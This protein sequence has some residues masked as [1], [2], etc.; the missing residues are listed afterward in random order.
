MVVSVSI[1]DRGPF[2]FLVDTGTNTTLIDPELATELGIAAQRQSQAR[3]SCQRHRCASLLS[4]DFPGG[5]CIRFKP[6]SVGGAASAT[7]RSG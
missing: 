6:G 5:A 2:D 3:Q 1:N 4:P 7:H